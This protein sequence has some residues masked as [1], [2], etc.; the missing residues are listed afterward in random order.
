MTD[1]IQ[2]LEAGTVEGQRKLL[3]EVWSSLCPQP[4]L[5]DEP[6]WQGPGTLR[7][8]LYHHWYINKCS[9]HTM[10]ECGAYLDAVKMLLPEGHSWA[11]GSCGE[12]EMPWACVT[13]NSFDAGCP[14]FTGSAITEALAL[15]A[16]ILRAKEAVAHASPAV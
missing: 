7:Q 16:A 12:Y 9:F 15:A 6:E 14:D 3:L 2:R 8:P 5:E 11:G 13:T 1:L 10:I 4:K